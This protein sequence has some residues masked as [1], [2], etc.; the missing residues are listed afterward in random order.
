VTRRVWLLLAFL[1]ACG[2][3]DRER[4]STP[5]SPE[6][7]GAPDV[8]VVVQVDAASDPIP[9]AAYGGELGGDVP[10]VA[11]GVGLT[12]RIELATDEWSDLLPYVAFRTRGLPAVSRDGA[13]VAVF[14]APQDCCRGWGWLEE[15]LDVYDVAT[16]KVAR[17]IAVWRLR[18]VDDLDVDTPGVQP[19][20]AVA[21]KKAAA[22]MARWKEALALAQKELSG[23]WETLG[24]LSEIEPEG[25]ATTRFAGEG[26]SAE[27]T[28]A[29]AEQVDFPP[30]VV[31]RGGAPPASFPTRG[32]VRPVPHCR[33][34]VWP[35][36][37]YAD[38]KRALM[39]VT[40][41]LG[42]NTPDGCERTD[43]RLL[44][45]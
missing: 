24:T 12:P 28:F 36:R 4:S 26:I 6:D 41:S 8:A 2:R 14:E 42:Y 3:C 18:D 30:L 35:T 29:T 44:A 37:M 9:W 31:R 20:S 7:A 43:T 25:G 38:P 15:R 19:E 33:S 16:R 27:M 45:L 32:W 39:L 13:R 22:A 21:R 1:P 5:T 23:E 34:G 10:V 40:M 17:S 11:A